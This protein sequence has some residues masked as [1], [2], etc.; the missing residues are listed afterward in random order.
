MSPGHL[1]CAF[2]VRRLAI[3]F[4]DHAIE[5]HLLNH[6]G[7][8]SKLWYLRYSIFIAHPQDLRAVSSESS[9]HFGDSQPHPAHLSSTTKSK[10][11]LLALRECRSGLS[12]N[13]LAHLSISLTGRDL[14]VVIGGIN[15][16]VGR[17][18]VEVGAALSSPPCWGAIILSRSSQ[19][20]HL[21]RNDLLSR[22]R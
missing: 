9:S 22:E 11:S 20:D 8:R 18:G 13:Q 6:G 21:H 10:P 2:V 17:I 1:A 3:E 7:D 15:L 16:D 5:R 14:T 12:G 19:I 4:A